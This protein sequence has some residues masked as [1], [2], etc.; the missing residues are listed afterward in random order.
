MERAFALI[1]QGRDRTVAE[2]LTDVL[3]QAVIEP[4]LATTLRKMENGQKCSLRF[5]PEGAVLKP[6]GTYTGAGFSRVLSN[7]EMS[8][9]KEW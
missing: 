6:T 1:A 2:V 9:K 7:P 5:C 3:V 8:L 4:H